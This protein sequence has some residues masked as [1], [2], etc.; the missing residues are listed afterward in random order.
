MSSSLRLRHN[1]DLEE[2]RMRWM[3]SNRQDTADR[4]HAGILTCARPI[5]LTALL[6]GL[7]GSSLAADN[8]SPSVQEKKAM[9]FYDLSA[10]DIDGRDVPLN[11]WQG[12]VALVV[13][14]ASECGFTPQYTGLQQLYTDYKDK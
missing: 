13:N 3:R 5:L 10:R 2:S 8:P 11:G 12:K 14:V 1:T 7:T 6:V 4:P 9:S